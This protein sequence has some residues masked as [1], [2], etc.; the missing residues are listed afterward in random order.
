MKFKHKLY[1]LVFIT[2]LLMTTVI[3]D[4]NVLAEQSDSTVLLDLSDNQQS[5]E[6]YTDLDGEW[7]FFEKELLSPDEVKE[8]LSNEP[9]SVVSLPS[10][11]DTQKGEINSFGTYSTTIKIPKSYVGETLAIHVPYQYSAYSLY[12]DEIEV[13]RNGVVG[14]D[15]A[16]HTSEMAPKTG[17]FIA[18]SDEVLLTMQVSSFD[19][20]RG[21]F[22]NTIYFGEASIVAQK[23]NSNMIVTLFINGSIFIIGLFMFL[24]ALYR[25]KEHL[26]FIFGMFAMLISARALFAVPFYYTL[27]L[28]MSWLWGTRLEYILT[29][30]TS[31]FYVIL[32]WKWHEEEFSKKIMYGLVTVH[33]GL[34]ITTLFTQPVFFQALFFNI[35]YLA[36]PTFF[37]MIYVISKSIRN[38]NRNAKINLI[39]MGLIF[40][41][42]FN[43]FAIGQNWYQSITLML[44]AVG[45][46]VLIH[47]ILMSKDFADSVRKTEQQNK[48]L[49]ALNSSNEELTIQLQK[50][51]KQKDDFLANT[52]HEL[53]NPLHGIINIAQS[54]LHNRPNHLDEKTQK[55]LEIQLT[56]GHHM[57]RT[58]ED[59]LDVTRLKE[60][61]IHLQRERLDIQ[62]ISAGVV[63]MLQVLIENKN[64]QM[65]V[66]IPSDFPILAAD[67]N[68][69]IQILFNLLHNAV[70]FTDEG[71]I[72]INADV[73]E[74]KA[75]IHITDTGIGMNE[76]TLRTIFDPYEQGDSSI[77]A[78]GGGLGLGLSICK[79]LVEMHGGAIKVNSVLGEGSVFTFTLPLAE[80]SFE[81][82]VAATTSTP[83]MDMGELSIKETPIAMNHAMI[84]AFTKNTPV[85]YRPR[86]LAVDD[87]P[88]NLQVL[89]NILSEDQYEVEIVTSGKEALKQLEEKEWDLIISDVMMP[90]MSGY[91]L[92]RS[93]RERFSISEL[94]ILLLTARSNP[95]DVYTGF[96]AG[97]NDYVTKPVDAVELNV[98][99][100]ALTDLQASIKERLG[101]EAAWLQAQIRPHFLLNTLNAIVSLSEID[102]PRM[103]RL[104]EKLA[105]YLQS[106]FYLKNLD[107]VVPLQTELDLLESY[108]YIEKERFGDRLQ[109]KWE[110]DEVQDVR[111][112]PLS[113]QTLVEN[114][115]NHG[116]LK[117]IEGGLITIRI[118]K[119]D[120]YTEI[121]II[122]DGVGMD[123]E[124]VEQLFTLHPDRKK[125]I[126]LNNTE[127]RLKRLY[128]KGLQ[129]RSTPGVGTRIIFSVPNRFEM[130]DSID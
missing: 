56:I 73:Q 105:H 107:K 35:F 127:Q 98:R 108:L 95:E 16:S 86:I 104:L 49:L 3:D 121:S 25:R 57:S 44:P 128:G 47:V 61:R 125:G 39:G 77:T 123:E 90:I 69:V 68:R 99:V 115:I 24:F 76:K 118:R 96:L 20:I 63:D 74:K 64:I 58:L 2:I 26:F 130:K 33:L 85:S 89:T 92:T 75:H 119:Q 65:E 112:P 113:I 1:L 102:T 34:I 50:E 54:I 79:Q 101:M 70:K 32:L 37:Y 97:A 12:I 29:E 120:G 45:V 17:Y 30:A 31:M 94:P 83:V 53:R 13:A 87:D 72:T 100:H 71:T 5:E 4:S 22:E 6:F 41:A 23:F 66:R 10:S 42:F 91:D 59:L 46:Y 27:I 7:N 114:A 80:E 52:S 38:N 126:G 60:H 93:I 40:L 122:D 18:Q 36:V 62:G 110:L 14:G 124:K 15:S 48:Q 106:S 82:Q 78:I 21:G 43:D 9:G 84:E 55:D 129:V 116:V 81:G 11:F 28:D 8:Q 51:M 111:I 117:Q 67:K 103:A 19:H 88:V 109:V